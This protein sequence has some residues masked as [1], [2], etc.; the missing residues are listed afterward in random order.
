MYSCVIL[1]FLLVYKSFSHRSEGHVGFYIN[2]VSF[3]HL[4]FI[5]SILKIKY[6]YIIQ[7]NVQMCFEVFID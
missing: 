3:P 7:R 1:E 6:I 2:F 4:L 5:P